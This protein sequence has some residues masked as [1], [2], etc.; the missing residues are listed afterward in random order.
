MAVAA[1]VDRDGLLAAA[2]DH[3]AAAAQSAGSGVD[4]Q[5]TAGGA[6]VGV[7]VDAALRIQGECGGRTPA[8]RL[9]H[10]D[11]ASRSGGAAGVQD[12]DVA[13]LQI[14]AELGA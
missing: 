5:M 8:D 13:S 1:L 14:G 9:L 10:V 4:G 11:V 7:Q 6:E 12:G 2:Q 3:G